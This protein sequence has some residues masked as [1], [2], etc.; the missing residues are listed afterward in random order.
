[1]QQVLPGSQIPTIVV[2]VVVKHSTMNHQ[3]CMYIQEKD[4][5]PVTVTC[6]WRTYIQI[7]Y[8]YTSG[9]FRRMR[10]KEASHQGSRHSEVIKPTTQA[11]DI[12]SFREAS[13][14]VKTEDGQAKAR[15]LAEQRAAPA[16]HDS[17]MNESTQCRLQGSED[18][19]AL[20][21][22]HGLCL[23]FFNQNPPD[24]KA[25]TARVPWLQRH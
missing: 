17:W 15:R 25:P 12:V 2:V 11:R 7:Q 9:L 16:W 10:P 23:R 21:G 6:N 8:S 3:S 22:G 19:L 14:A 5:L 24:L 1:M 13:C 4:S 20:H 18:S